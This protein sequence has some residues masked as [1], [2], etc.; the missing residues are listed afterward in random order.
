MFGLRRLYLYDA[1]RGHRLAVLAFLALAAC[2]PPAVTAP[3]P[4]QVRVAKPTGEVVAA[5]SR[6]LTM[7]G[8][9][10]AAV[11]PDAG[12]VTAK[13]TAAK[14]GNY[15]FIV[16][17]HAKGSVSEVQLVSTITTSLSARPVGSDSSEVVISSRVI[18]SWPRLMSTMFAQPENETTC[19]SN[20]GIEQR[21]MTALGR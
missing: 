20:G 21:L 18:S 11:D 15:D 16:C 4:S 9:E 19:V 5:A 12:I 13:R 14:D 2:M 1:A 6:E 7:A 8:F 10:I 17:R 3:E